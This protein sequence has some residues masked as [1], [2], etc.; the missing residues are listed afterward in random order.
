MIGGSGEGPS[1][2][3]APELYRGDPQEEEPGGQGAGAEDV[4]GGAQGRWARL[5]QSPSQLAVPLLPSAKD[6]RGAAEYAAEA[7]ARRRPRDN[8]RYGKA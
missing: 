8:E 2:G 4:V 5:Y 3:E 6:A 1:R 7:T